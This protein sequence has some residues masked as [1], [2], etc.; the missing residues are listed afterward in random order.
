MG[1]TPEE[2]DFRYTHKEIA[3]SISV[4]IPDRWAIKRNDLRQKFATRGGVVTMTRSTSHS[5]TSEGALLIRKDMWKCVTELLLC[6]YVFMCV[7]ACVGV[8]TCANGK[9]DQLLTLSLS[10]SSFTLQRTQ[11]HLN[12]NKHNKH[13]DKHTQQDKNTTTAD[14]SCVHRST[15]Q[16]STCLLHYSANMFDAYLIGGTFGCGTASN[17]TKFGVIASVV[18][19]IIAPLLPIWS[20]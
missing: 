17:L 10:L 16:Y 7:C 4:C 1:V 15:V 11:R 9:K 18:K 2:H 12:T 3:M 6:V 13:N 8:C 14:T 19:R 5:N 20:Q